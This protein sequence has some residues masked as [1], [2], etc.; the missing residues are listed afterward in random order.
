MD[1]E[2]TLSSLLFSVLHCV[3]KVKLATIDQVEVLYCSAAD[4]F[5][6]VVLGA[7]EAAEVVLGNTR[8]RSI[9]MRG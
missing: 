8:G 4:R 9:T 3:G 2:N 7:V 5:C 1:H 6:P